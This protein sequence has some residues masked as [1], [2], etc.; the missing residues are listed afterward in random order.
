[1]ELQV[2]QVMNM[3]QVLQ[4]ISEEDLPFGLAY[5]LTGVIEE[6]VLV[7]K[8]Y[9]EQVKKLYDKYIEKDE[10]GEFKTEWDSR[11]G[12]QILVIKNDSEEDFNQAGV[13]LLN[14][15][16]QIPI[17]KLN[18]EDWEQA[19]IKINLQEMMIL[20]PLFA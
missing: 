19:N 4:D 8:R 20:K 15:R 5:R 6:L 7:Q 9:N 2:A 13:D 16:V 1:M 18:I 10:S 12:E 11:K 17:E 3:L 14:E